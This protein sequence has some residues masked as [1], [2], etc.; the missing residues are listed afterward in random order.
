MAVIHHPSFE[1]PR[2][3]AT[4]ARDTIGVLAVLVVVVL[5]IGLV[6]GI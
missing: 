5:L 1:S 3:S 2:E 4:T 6:G